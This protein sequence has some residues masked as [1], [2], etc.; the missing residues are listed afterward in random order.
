M[1]RASA[2]SRDPRPGTRCHGPPDTTRP[3]RPR[4]AAKVGQRNHAVGKEARQL[5][6]GDVGDRGG[7]SDA[8][9]HRRR[10]ARPPASRSNAGEGKAVVPWNT[11]ETPGRCVR[12]GRGTPRGCRGI[13]RRVFFGRATERRPQTRYSWRGRVT[14]WAPNKRGWCSPGYDV[15]P[16]RETWYRRVLAVRFAPYRARMKPIRRWRGTPLN[17]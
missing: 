11:S 6:D 4:F 9:E 1:N 17:R 3:R 16:T 10:E 12:G 13:I 7:G 5:L 14:T 8:F 2:L 15:G